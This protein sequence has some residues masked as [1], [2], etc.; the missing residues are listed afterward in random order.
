MIQNQTCRGL[1]KKYIH[2]KLRRIVENIFFRI[3]TFLLIFLDIGFVIAE[4]VIS[5][6][7]DYSSTIIRYLELVLSVYFLVEARYII[8]IYLIFIFF[9]FSSELSL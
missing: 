9:R 1:N 7:G 4:I 8:S 2:W 6:A 5:C 3:F